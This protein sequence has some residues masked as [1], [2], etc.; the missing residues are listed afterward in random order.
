MEPEEVKVLISK[1]TRLEMAD[2][3]DDHPEV[4]MLSNITADQLVDKLARN[5]DP[6]ASN[7]CLSVSHVHSRF[8][9]VH[10]A[11]C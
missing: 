7:D 10:G 8:C 1:L 3:P 2:I 11:F 4:S 5:T 9:T 6:E